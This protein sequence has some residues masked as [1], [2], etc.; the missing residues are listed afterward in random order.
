MRKGSGVPRGRKG[1]SRVVP[2]T[3]LGFNEIFPVVVCSTTGSNMGLPTF[4][5][6]NYTHR[7]ALPRV[8]GLTDSMF[9]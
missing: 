9:I 3:V 4:P 2:L 8:L 6:V 5:Q 1:G 7:K